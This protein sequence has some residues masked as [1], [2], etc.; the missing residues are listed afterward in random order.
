MPN[1]KPENVMRHGQHLGCGRPN[2]RHNRCRDFYLGRGCDGCDPDKQ[3]DDA[4]PPAKQPAKKKA[5]SPGG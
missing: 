4:T 2:F 1:P 3:S 5:A